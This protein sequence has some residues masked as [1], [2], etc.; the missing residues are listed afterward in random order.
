MVQHLSQCALLAVTVTRRTERQLYGN[1]SGSWRGLSTWSA[2]RLVD[3][4]SPRVCTAS[5]SFRLS[6]RCA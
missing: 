3:N 5:V 2:V 1:H 4:V 6:R